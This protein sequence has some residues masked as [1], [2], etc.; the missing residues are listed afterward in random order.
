[1]SDIDIKKHTRTYIGVFIALGVLT[2]V[3]VSVSYFHFVL[4]LAI[5]VAL[6]IATVKGSM[7][8]SFF[9]H[10]AHERRVIYLALMITVVFFIALMF[11]P[12]LGY[13]DRVR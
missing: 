1:M 2:V 9:M 11:L 7:V 5:A 6:I 13:L 10:L 3:T 12:L 4:P 8:A